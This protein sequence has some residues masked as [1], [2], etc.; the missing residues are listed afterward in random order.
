MT[1]PNSAG[2]VPTPLR[3][4]AVAYCAVMTLG[5]IL[6]VTAELA[7]GGLGPGA[8][9]VLQWSELHHWIWGITGS[10]VVAAVLL[11]YLRTLN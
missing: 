9:T 1:D 6:F 11:R 7:H 10:A 4:T 3:Y 8:A 2:H 5:L